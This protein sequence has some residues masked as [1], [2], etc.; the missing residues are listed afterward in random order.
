MPVA[1]VRSTWSMITWRRTPGLWRSFIFM[2]PSNPRGIPS[3]PTR[4]S[5]DLGEARRAA[6]DRWRHD[7]RDELPRRTEGGVEL[8]R[9]GAR[10]EEHTSELQS[11]AYI[12]C[13]LLL[14]K[15]KV[16]GP[17]GAC[18]SQACAAPGP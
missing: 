13:R 3:F 8:Q 15:K 2:A 12:V 18:R 7:V 6:H 17:P 9:D 4:R 16:S 11:L 5:S 14:E 10:S 1:G